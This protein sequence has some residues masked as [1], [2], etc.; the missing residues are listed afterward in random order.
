MP[1]TNC[2]PTCGRALP[3]AKAPTTLAEDATLEQ[4]YAYYKR[5]SPLEDARFIFRCKPT[6]SPEL[7]AD[8]RA[9]VARIEAGTAGTRTQ[10]QQMT[11]RLQERHRIE[12]LQWPSAADSERRFWALVETH[13]GRARAAG[14]TSAPGTLSG[15]RWPP[16]LELIEM[17]EL[18]AKHATA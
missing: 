8:W 15:G 12:L 16:P 5:I 17:A 6:L 3:K 1:T 18:K 7:E 4:R 11:G 10:I 14:L 13:A 2:C 9:H